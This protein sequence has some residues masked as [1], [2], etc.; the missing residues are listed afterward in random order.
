MGI[1]YFD[2]AATSVPL[3]CAVSA[4]VDAMAVIGNPSSVHKA[5][6][7]A[8][9]IIDTARK[10]VANSLYCKPEEII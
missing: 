4:A 7:N 2:S 1:I 10:S 9:K 6:L 5:G 8:K 3:D